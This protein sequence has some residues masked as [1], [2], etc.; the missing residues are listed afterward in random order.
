MAEK[1]AAGSLAAVIGRPITNWLAP[2]AI[3]A[4]GVSTR[5]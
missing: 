4:A 1:A 3:A 2:A 5:R